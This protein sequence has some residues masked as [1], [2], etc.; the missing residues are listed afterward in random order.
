MGSTL[1]ARFILFSLG[2]VSCSSSSPS[3]CL[4]V[5]L[6][7]F[8]CFHFN[9]HVPSSRKAFFPFNLSMSAPQTASLGGKNERTHTHTH[10]HSLSLSHKH[11]LFFSL[12]SSP[13]SSF[14]ST[15]FADSFHM[16]PLPFSCSRFT[17]NIFFPFALSTST[18]HLRVKHTQKGKE[19]LF[20]FVSNGKS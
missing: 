2:L 14:F 20:P 12:F 15:C 13:L 9:F 18:F 1:R 7:L 10:T 4:H 19:P 5:S 3:S 16:F 17:H 6:N 8:T 11:L